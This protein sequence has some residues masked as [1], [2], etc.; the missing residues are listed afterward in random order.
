MY[1]LPISST[2]VVAGKYLA[3]V[4]VFALPMALA[5]VYPF[6]FS[7]FGDVYLPTSYGALA[8]F[9]FLGMA[10]ISIGMFI[11]SLT[12]SQGMAAGLCVAVMLLCYYT[13]TLADYIAS[14]AFTVVEPA[15]MPM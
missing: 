6:V 3:M 8:A 2:E 9:V 11:S 1:L 4:F 12:E 10:L 14:T 7:M 13:A 15:S 5:C